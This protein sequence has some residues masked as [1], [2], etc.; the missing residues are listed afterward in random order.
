MNTIITGI[1]ITLLIVLTLGAIG[2]F[3]YRRILRFAKGVERGIK[4]V[5]L[6]IHLPPPSDD[7]EVGG[8]DVRDVIQ[9]RISQA[10]V[11]YSLIASTALKGFKSKFY[12]QRH[13]SLEVVAINGVIRY[14]A[15]VPVVLVSVVR[16]AILTAYPGAQLEEVEDH[17]IFSPT[18]K[19]SGTIGGEV[20]LKQDYPYPIATVNQLKRDAMQA[21]INA[22]SSLESGDGAG[23]QIMLRPARSGWEKASTSLVNKKRKDKGKNSVG[24][25]SI[26]AAPLKVPEKKD[27]E[28]SDKQLSSLEQ[29]VLD[30]IEEKT[31]HP[32]YEVLIR[33]ITSSSTA[34]R[35]QAIL[36][37]VISTFA[38]FDAPG[39][40]GFK[41]N[42][43][44]DIENFVTAFI[45]RFFPPEIN[46]N[47]LNSVELATLFHLPDA[48]FTATSQVQRQFSKQ[49]D[50]PTKLSNEG[51][52]MGHNVFRGI[53]KEIR[54]NPEDRR[55]HTYIV[56]QTGTGKSVLLENLIAQ[57]MLHGNGFAFI[58][59][60]GDAAEKLLSMVPK[61]R[62]EDV[63][64]FNP[65]DM[66]YPMGLNLFESASTEQQDF[67]IQEA[68][69]ML[70]KLYD[71]RHTGIIGPRYEH[72]FRNAALT[73]MADP[74]GGTFV[75]IPKLFNDDAYVRAK[76]KYVT[77]PTVRDF[78][79]KEMPA[80]QRSNEFGEVKSWF[81]SKFGAFLSNQMMRNIIGQ[82]KSSFD[83]RQVMD[84]GKILIV[85]LSKG[86]LG[87]MNSMLL[88][89]IF[90]M[91]FQAAAMS[92]SSVPES[93]RKDFSL[94]VDEFQNFSTE[95]FAHILSEARKYRLNLIVANQFISQLSEEIREAVFGNVGTII[96]FRTGPNDA[97]FLVKQFAPAFS[98]RDLVNLPIGNVAA[99][100]L[101]GGLPSQPF[102][103]VTMPP[104]NVSNPQLGIALKQLSAAKYGRA[105]AQ[106]EKKIFGRLETKPTPNPFE[107]LGN[108][109]FPTRPNSPATSSAGSS[110]L[111][112][113]LAKRK[114]TSSSAAP[115]RNKPVT[116]SRFSQFKQ[117]IPNLSPQPPQSPQPKIRPPTA[118]TNPSSPELKTS[119][120][121]DLNPPRANIADPVTLATTEAITPA[122]EPNEPVP[123]PDFSSPTPVARPLTEPTVVPTPPVAAAVQPPSPPVTP[124]LNPV[125]KTVG[126]SAIT[127]NLNL[128]SGEL[129]IDEEGNV[130]QA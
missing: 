53:K 6:L 89:M 12:G 80:S 14:Y 59:P 39:L 128:Q 9:E 99:R 8:R 117:P 57:D 83:L 27:E 118:Q 63:I 16:Q 49:V 3:V 92:R 85:N 127:D 41:F 113:W 97:D 34:A 67:L 30:S 100:L 19:I 48:Q 20:I 81:V 54:L 90:V 96:S 78:W 98:E 5:P 93:E 56:G 109:N 84:E 42:P 91:K 51:L 71:P 70:Y 122:P 125:D 106:V 73:V 130:H 23:V 29:S 102:S 95:S 121:A 86:R 69:N 74:E 4:M 105:R 28:P 7:T 60:H 123:P 107:N 114:Q 45:F 31:K 58:D 129:Y 87:E 103:M 88:G 108:N 55:R 33:V 10:E 62:V 43:A 1:I 120:L 68:I 26:L 50:G 110:F 46:K 2:F 66:Q 36:H 79:L 32:G 104:V 44:R 112:E 76:L 65:G 25:R 38:L 77:D 119:T 22:L 35:S 11:L 17:N 61:N 15:A 18:G 82:T 47:I 72:L 52:L 64:Y 40:N 21:L 75:D 24:W 115:P 126:Q 101:I 124:K 116:G 111:D 13:L 37:N 94:F